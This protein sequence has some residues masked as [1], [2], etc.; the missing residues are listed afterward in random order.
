VNL[1]QVQPELSAG[2]CPASVIGFLFLPPFLL[3]VAQKLDFTQKII[4]HD[5]V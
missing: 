2:S 4:E 1:H 3:P 5:Y